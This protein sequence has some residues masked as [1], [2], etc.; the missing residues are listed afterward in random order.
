MCIINVY[1]L[2]YKDKN[3][4][5]CTSKI[6]WC[7]TNWFMIKFV[8]NNPL[9]FKFK[10]WIGD[11][12]ANNFS[13]FFHKI[14]LRTIYERKIYK[15]GYCFIVVRSIYVWLNVVILTYIL[16][17]STGFIIEQIFWEKRVIVI[18]NNLLL[19]TIRSSSPRTQKDKQREW[20]F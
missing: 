5:R 4:Y 19:S 8:G 6:V 2:N 16:F 15:R 18:S 13:S 14:M 1:F 10:N 7:R 9:S 11:F 12:N 17:Y 20:E 3:T